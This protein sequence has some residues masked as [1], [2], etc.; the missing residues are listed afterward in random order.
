MKAEIFIHLVHWD[1]P[2]LSMVPGTQ[3]AVTSF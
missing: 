3:E 1:I 2:E